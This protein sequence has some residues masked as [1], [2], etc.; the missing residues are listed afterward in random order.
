MI[1][2]EQMI[3]LAKEMGIGV[4]ENTK[5]G[6]FYKDKNGKLKKIKK[7][8]LFLKNSAKNIKV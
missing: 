2:I 1:T 8:N 6:F 4:E 7:E 5:G 3:E